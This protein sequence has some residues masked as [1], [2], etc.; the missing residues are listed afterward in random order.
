MAVVWPPH[1][2]PDLL[3]ISHYSPRDPAGAAFPGHTPI[4]FL[5]L[6]DAPSLK[7][8]VKS[9]PPFN[10][11]PKIYSNHILRKHYRSPHR[12]MS[13]L[14][15]SLSS[16]LSIC[17]SSSIS[18]FPFFFPVFTSPKSRTMSDLTQAVITTHW[19]HPWRGR[20]VLHRFP[21]GSN[22]QQQIKNIWKKKILES[23]KRLNLNL[24]Q[25]CNYCIRYYK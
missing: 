8:P 13:T 1:T 14:L 9:L 7:R 21:M 6:H 23:A 20:L 4:L 5:W 22:N 24:P 3:L 11:Q 16:F 25:A 10:L 18:S 2:C 15:G 17:R 19:T 12:W